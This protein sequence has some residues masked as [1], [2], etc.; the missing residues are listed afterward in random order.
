MTR[1]TGRIGTMVSTVQ[2]AWRR[3]DAYL[4]RRIRQR[5]TLRGLGFTLITIAIGVAAFLTANNL[6]FLLLAL[7]LSALLVSGF[8]SRLGLAGLEVD[9]ELPRHV[10]ARVPCPATV[11]LRNH[12]QWIPSFAL[13]LQGSP[14]SGFTQPVF[15]TMLAGGGQ[16]RVPLTLEFPR[17]GQYREDA[18][19]FSTRFPFGFTDRR[20]RV[21]IERDLIVYPSVLPQPG[22]EQILQRLEGEIASRQRGRGDDFHR[23]RPYEHGEATRHVDWKTTA[24][25][26]ALQVRE[27]VQPEQP[28]VEIVL[29][30]AIGA[31]QMEW[32]EEAIDCCAYLGW[33]LSERRAPFRFR[34]QL[35][36]LRIPDEAEVYDMLRFLALVEPLYAASN[37]P[38]P[39]F[40]SNTDEALVVLFSRRS[41]TDPRQ[42]PDHGTAR[43]A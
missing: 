6:L 18:F 36:D 30:L 31:G 34:T 21:A 33:S 12:K 28:Q 19:E 7:L 38:D 35:C 27:F 32:L 43:E 16:A 1:A 29:D 3:L 20:V 4:E 17:R 25:T 22:F 2:S 23:I 39:R 14:Q 11:K 37:V 10:A 5:V 40:A 24:H 42:R 15:F 8:V 13:R 26:G 9:L 41:G